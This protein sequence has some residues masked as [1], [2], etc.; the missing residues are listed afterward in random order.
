MLNRTSGGSSDSELNEVTVMPSGALSTTAVA[1]QTPVGKCPRACRNARV[2]K[3]GSILMDIS[4]PHATAA[5]F[6][7][8][9]LMVPSLEPSRSEAA[10]RQACWPS[11]GPPLLR[12]A[13]R[14]LNALRLESLDAQ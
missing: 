13:R 8:S 10:R 6:E 3:V 9:Q 12:R 7:L 11:A 5:E 2:S 1:T 14:P 4:V